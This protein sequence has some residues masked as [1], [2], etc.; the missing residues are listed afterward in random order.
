MMTMS[1]TCCTILAFRPG[2][3]PIP[4]RTANAFEVPLSVAIR[5]IQAVKEGRT[6]LTA[7]E[8]SEGQISFLPQ[9]VP[10]GAQ[11]RE[12]NPKKR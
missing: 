4:T 3:S 9:A 10:A 7:A 8:K 6:A 12:Q 1:I 5:A 11:K 2:S